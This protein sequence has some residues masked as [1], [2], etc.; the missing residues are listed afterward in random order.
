[1]R[2]AQLTNTADAAV[3]GA[4]NHRI[5]VLIPFTDSGGERAPL[6]EGIR[7]LLPF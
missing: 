1:M 2:A 4:G 5:R 6:L 3:D 7:D